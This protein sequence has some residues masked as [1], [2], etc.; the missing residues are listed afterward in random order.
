MKAV[1]NG[2]TLAESDRTIEVE[3][4]QYFPPESVRQELLQQSS[5]TSI[6]PWKGT[7]RYYTIVADGAENHDAAWSYPDPKEKATHFKDYV[8]F[9]RGVEIQQ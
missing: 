3:G 2:V 4:N 6:C 5:T 7:A 8:A 1:W 9:W